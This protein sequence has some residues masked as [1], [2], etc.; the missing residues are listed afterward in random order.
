MSVTA[1]ARYISYITLLNFRARLQYRGEFLLE[2]F[3]GVLWQ[4][5]VLLFV[6]V[7]L[8]QF[9]GVAGWSSTEVLL[10]TSMRLLSHALYVLMFANITRVPMYIQFG[11]LDGYLIRPIPPYLQAL[12][13]SFSVSGLGDLAVAIPLLLIAV[14]HVAAG[15]GVGHFLFLVVAVIAGTLLEAS[16]QNFIACVSLRLPGGEILSTWIDEVMGSFGSYPLN[17]M[18]NAVQ[19][20]LTFVLPLAFATYLPASL[21]VGNTELTGLPYTVALLSPLVGVGAFL[22]SLRTWRKSLRLYT[23]PGG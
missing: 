10:L 14:A 12:T 1:I 2:V 7:I 23:S 3:N 19:F 20:A 21:L 6:G 22:F 13:S 18:P 11:N 9:P 4:S 5:S 16:V 17:I 8:T 15:W